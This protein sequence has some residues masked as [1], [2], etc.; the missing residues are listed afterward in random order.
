[1]TRTRRRFAIWACVLGAA[2]LAVGI[3]V[4]A[5]A[6]LKTKSAS[7]TVGPDSH[8][9]AT[10]VCERG[11][12][13][14]SGGFE[15]APSQAAALFPTASVGRTPGRSFL[16]PLPRRWMSAAVNLGEDPASLTGYAYCRDLSE[17][18]ETGWSRS[19][20]GL[21]PSQEKRVRQRCGPSGG[22]AVSGSFKTPHAENRS[23]SVRGSHRVGKHVWVVIMKAVGTGVAGVS[24]TG[25]CR[26]EKV[27]EMTETKVA[28]GG[29]VDRAVA[30][31]KRGQRVISGGFQTENFASEGG[32]FVYASRKQGRRGWIVRVR[33]TAPETFTSYAYCWK[34]RARDP[35]PAGV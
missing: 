10:A 3:G 9:S 19:R 25:Y 33:S 20:L 23:V 2:T 6:K 27:R 11:T 5:G 31:C 29:D 22:Q 35:Q 28:S 34:K 13:T 15:L 17:L 8:A 26:N 14:I 32:P 30:R 18:D 21:A 12:R 7:T 1:M 4:A 24:A 16:E